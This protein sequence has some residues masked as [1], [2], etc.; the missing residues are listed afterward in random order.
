[1][2]MSMYSKEGLIHRSAWKKNSRKFALTKGDK[3]VRSCEDT[4]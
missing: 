4:Y 1:M 3:R 2:T